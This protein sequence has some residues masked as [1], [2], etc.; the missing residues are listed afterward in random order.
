[1][2]NAVHMVMGEQ[3]ANVVGAALALFLAKMEFDLDCWKDTSEDDQN[4]FMAM[5]SVKFCAEHMYQNLS[6]LLGVENE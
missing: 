3:E 2:R 1:M 5:L 4:E 6:G